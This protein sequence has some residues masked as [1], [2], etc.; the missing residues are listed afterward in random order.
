MKIGVVVDNEFDH[1]HRVQKEIRLLQQEGHSISVLCFDFKKTYKTYPNLIVERVR[2]PRKVRDLLVLLSTNFNFYEA[3]WQKH[4]TTF[5]SKHKLDALH[6]HDLYLAKAASK[7][8]QHSQH[9]IPLTLDLHENYPAAI[10]SYEWAIKGWRKYVVQ[11][12]KWYH[13]EGDYLKYADHLIV[14]SDSFKQDLTQRFPFLESNTIYVHPNM[15]DFESYQAFEKTDYAV[16][17]DSDLP[18]LFYFGVV[19]KR[20]GI[21]DVLPW[22]IELLEEGTQFHTL[23]I[24]PTDKADKSRFQSFIDHPVLKDYITYIPWADV[25]YLP[26]YLKKISIGLAPFQVN[27][28]HDSGVANKLFQYMYGE[29][30]ILATKCKAQQ[31]LI[32]SSASGLLYSTKEEFKQA[33]HELITSKSLRAELGAN[34]KKKLLALYEN[35]TDRQFLNIYKELN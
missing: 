34:G 25:K 24:G 11:P 29:I 19:A 2:I 32:E 5:I 10:N 7:G 8:I 23:I 20:R 21:M 33:V 18:T 16:A 15:P 17:F 26:A 1:D 13:K 12:Q 35:K 3:L 27:A 22:I 4:I 6:V 31:Q 14:L 9:D 30:P 28:Q